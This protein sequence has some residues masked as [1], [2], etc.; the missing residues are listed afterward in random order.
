MAKDPQELLGKIAAIPPLPAIASR[1][2]ELADNDHTG[3]LELA[4]VVSADQGLTAQLIKASNSS[5]YGFSRR[6][7][8]VR[9]AIVLLGF[10][11][12]RQMSV[13]ASI[14]KNFRQGI[15]DERFNLDLFWG[16]SVVVAI[17]SEAVARATRAAKPEDAFTA[18]I[19]HDIGRLV[20]YQELSRE[21]NQSLELVTKSGL[22]LGEAEVEVTG[23]SHDMVGRALADMWHFPQPLVDA[24]GNHHDTTLT[25]ERNGIAGIVSL[26]NR[27]SWHYG[28]FSG[29]DAPSADTPL[30]PELAQIE[31]ICGGMELVLDRALY[32]IEASSGAPGQ[33][34]SQSA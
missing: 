2:L 26:A 28:L 5:L 6:V 1:I 27:L 13:S 16:H 19:L 23:Y 18:G 33:W 15:P 34:F 8:T 7:T 25:I 24:I 3:A 9:E 30:P 22:P 14:M 17:V 12:V 20:L 11:Q 4:N 31:A 21:F 32:F 29:Y 10:K